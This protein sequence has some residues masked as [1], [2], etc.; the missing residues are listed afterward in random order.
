[1]CRAQDV[2]SYAQNQGHNQVW[3]QIQ[4]VSDNWSKY[5]ETSQKD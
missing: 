5:Y 1:M 2:G 3:G 4:L